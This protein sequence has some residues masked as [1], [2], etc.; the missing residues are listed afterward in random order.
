M[1]LRSWVCGGL[2]E[3]VEK[4]N[5]LEMDSVAEA[6]LVNLNDYTFVCFSESRQ[7]YIFKIREK[8]VVKK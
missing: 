4:V 1:F 5:F 3:L 6:N 2:I 8:M 7:K